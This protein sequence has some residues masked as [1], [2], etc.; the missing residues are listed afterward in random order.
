[1]QREAQ[2]SD[3]QQ[4]APARQQ[5]ACRRTAHCLQEA[6]AYTGSARTPRRPRGL[7]RL[8]GYPARARWIPAHA[9]HGLLLVNRNA[10][11]DSPNPASHCGSGLGSP[12]MN[13]RCPSVSLTLSHRYLLR[14]GEG[15]LKDSTSHPKVVTNPIHW[16]A[17]S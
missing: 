10:P 16:R 17:L 6:E 5:P 8:P 14:P 7:C 12:S 1:M 3:P 9:A 4:N 2:W 15:L 11:G 13:P